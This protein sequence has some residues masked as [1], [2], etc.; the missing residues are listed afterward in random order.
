MQNES[1]LKWNLD[2]LKYSSVILVWDALTADGAKV[3]FVGGCVRDT[4]Q[5]R[6]VN[7]ID[8]ATDALPS[9]V[10]KLAKIAGLKVLETGLS[11]GSITLITNGSCFEVTTFRSDLIAD[12]RHSQ[13]EFSTNI[14]D[15]A[16]RRDFTMN[17]IYMTIDGEIIDPISGWK[18][19]VNRY[20]RFIGNPEER[21]REDYLRILRYFR[22]L[23]ICEADENRIDAAA[24]D[25]CARFKSGLKKLSKERTW[26]ELQKILSYNNPI[27]ALKKMESSGVLEE[28]LPFSKTRTLERFLTIEHQLS[29]GFMVIDRLAALNILCVDSCVKKLSLTKEYKTWVNKILVIT[30]DMSSLRVKGYKYKE[31]PV[32]SALGVFLASSTGTLKQNDMAEIKFGSFQRFPLET[33]DFMK[34]FLPSKELGDE[35]KRVKKIWF[36]SELK[37]NREEL[38]AELH[39]CS[40]L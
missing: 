22:F 13:V 15:D 3:F 29:S 36:N 28:I 8:I 7:D 16:K 34:F 14:E 26:Q 30:K 27:F 21:I 17:A 39:K 33:S 18:D 4:I 5:G 23:T 31:S 19:L 25:A 32:L 10:I 38:L 6:K 40:L 37:M 35:I 9:E 20:V 12:G 2:W 24:L 1:R 11:H